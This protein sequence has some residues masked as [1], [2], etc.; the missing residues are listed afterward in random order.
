MASCLV[1]AV[2]MIVFAC[3]AAAENAKLPGEAGMDGRT[4][5]A[6]GKTRM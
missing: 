1:A 4:L 2:L 3:V 6:A 5:M